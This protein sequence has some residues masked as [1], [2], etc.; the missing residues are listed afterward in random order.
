[1]RRCSTPRGTAFGMNVDSG[2]SICVVVK[3]RLSRAGESTKFVEGRQSSHILGSGT[4]RLLGILGC[5]ELPFD[6]SRT[7][8]DASSRHGKVGSTRPVPCL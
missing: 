6:G 5:G 7:G 3:P 2:A 1:M 8:P 4:R